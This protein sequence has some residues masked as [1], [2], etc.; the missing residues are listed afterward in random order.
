MPAPGRAGDLTIAARMPASGDPPGA[1]AC[2]FDAD[3]VI[4]D[5]NDFVDGY[6]HEAQLKGTITFGKFEDDAPAT[7]TMDDAASRFHYLRVNTATGE[8][9]MRYH[10]EFVS[11]TGRRYALD[12]T[13]YM[14]KDPDA[15]NA[16]RDLLGDYTTLYTRVTELLPGGAQ[17]DL[18]TALLKFRTFEDLAAA[19]NLAGFLASFQVTG[20]GDPA[21]Q[22]QARLRFL[23][24]TAQF[25]QR[26]YDPLVMAVGGQP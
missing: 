2:K 12:G 8:A 14:Q 15:P 10:I 26:E 11:S 6:E 18:G 7:F 9:E 21:V 4:R 22:L 23:A 13:K 17:R 3:M 20:T 19:A 25:V 5:V 1:V 16:I 24:F